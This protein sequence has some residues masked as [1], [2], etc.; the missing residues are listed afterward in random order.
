MRD[1]TKYKNTYTTTKYLNSKLKNISAEVTN[2]SFRFPFNMQKKFAFVM[3][4][5]FRKR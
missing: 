4:R 3:Q 5:I 2:V 1:T